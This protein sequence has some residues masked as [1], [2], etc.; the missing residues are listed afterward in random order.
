MNIPKKYT[1]IST[2]E[3]LADSSDM[4]IDSI[5]PERTIARFSNGRGVHAYRYCYLD[6][7]NLMDEAGSA[8]ELYGSARGLM[9]VNTNSLCDDRMKIVRS[10]LNDIVSGECTFARASTMQ[11]CIDW[12][13]KDNRGGELLIENSAKGLY[14]DYTNELLHRVRLSKVGEKKGLGRPYAARLQKTFRELVSYAINRSDSIISSWAPAIEK[15]QGIE[16]IPQGYLSDAEG[17][18]AFEMHRRFFWAYSDAVIN[19]ST[20]PLTV[21]LDDLGFKSLV[22][23]GYGNHNYN[24]WGARGEDIDNSWHQFAFSEQGFDSDWRSIIEKGTIMGVDIVRKKPTGF[25]RSVKY[26]NKRKFTPATIVQ[27]SNR[28]M[29]HFGYMLMFA[30]GCNS[31]H[32]DGIN[33]TKSMQKR[34]SGSERLIAHKN[35]SM[36]EEQL[37]SVSANFSKQWRQFL[38][39]REWMSKFHNK[40]APSY[41][42]FICVSRSKSSR[43]P[44][45]SFKA[46]TCN[47]L[48]NI[49]WPEGAPTLS[50]R[51]PRKVELQKK[52]EL[53]G[54]NVGLVASLSS[55]KEATVRKHYAFREQEE[56]SKQLSSFFKNLH[57]SASLRVSGVASAP[58]IEGGKRIPV[59]Q[60]VAESEGDIRLIQGIDERRAP[61]LSCGSPL[62]CF[63]CESFGIHS[64][65]TDIKRLLSVKEYI[66]YQSNHKSQSIN[67]HVQ[68]FLPVA[69][70]IDEIIEAFSQRD[71]T[72]KKIVKLASERIKC[73]DLDKFWLAH[74]NAIIDAMG[75]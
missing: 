47:E 14:F 25:K 50:T 32:L 23:F 54:G 60:C 30:S 48:K 57:L 9:R 4:T 71:S 63:F 38:R 61:E 41:G 59:G 68:K 28:A 36:N 66:R 24:N 1:E 17:Q 26:F 39:L 18:K 13:D 58:V 34:S 69:A 3:V 35:R 62:T 45:N 11:N 33:I 46:L 10:W 6:R 21:K 43:S 56:A 67:E 51:A 29:R 2:T 70:R 5:S 73:G 31:D 22:A 20:F 53:S 72:S 15:R 27:F 42:L 55:G 19:N 7:A 44:T 64:D 40:P 65:L 12:V 37:L 52:L 49:I 74:I 75:A 16:S 8:K